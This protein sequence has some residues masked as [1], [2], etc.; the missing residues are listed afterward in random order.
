[1]RLASTLSAACAAVALLPA[2]ASAQIVPISAFTG[3]LSESFET[4]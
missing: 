1:M 4:P 3:N 2:V